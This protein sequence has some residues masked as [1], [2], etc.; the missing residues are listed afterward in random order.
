MFPHLQTRNRTLEIL[1][2]F[3]PILE[4]EK[5]SKIGQN[6]KFDMLVLKWYD[7]DLKGRLF[8]TMLAHY[9]IEPDQR[10]SIDVLF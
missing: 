10:H 7:I 9:L 3:K 6:I 8:D 1:S 2:H 5:I 4:N